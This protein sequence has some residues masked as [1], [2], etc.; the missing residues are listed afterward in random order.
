MKQRNEHRF[1]RAKDTKM[2][3]R[4]KLEDWKCQTCLPRLLS[5]Q[6][7]ERTNRSVIE[8]SVQCDY[9]LV[10]RR[11]SW[12]RLQDASS[13][14]Q[15]DCTTL[16]EKSSA[17]N[18]R[19]RQI[20]TDGAWRTGSK[21]RDEKFEE[22]RKRHMENMLRSYVSVRRNDQRRSLK[23]FSRGGGQR[24]RRFVQTRSAREHNEDPGEKVS[25][26]LHTVQ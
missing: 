13:F 25:A 10:K 6:I 26:K 20:I 1:T 21:I 16:D 19:R 5:A 17:T 15:G 9:Y 22:E 3:E 18:A 8:L 23:G 7:T 11:M 12:C 14:W 4:K 2:E 24:I